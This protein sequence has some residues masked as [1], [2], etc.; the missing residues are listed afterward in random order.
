[1]NISQATQWQSLES[2]TWT[3]HLAVDHLAL[4]SGTMT[5]R[6]LFCTRQLS[7]LQPNLL[8]LPGSL[9]Q[10]LIQLISDLQA[11]RYERDPSLGNVAIRN[12]Y[13]RLQVTLLDSFL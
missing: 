9:T 7:M 4:E 10:E 11:G 8:S 1:M 6:L 3:F 5:E 12:Y 13:N 2:V